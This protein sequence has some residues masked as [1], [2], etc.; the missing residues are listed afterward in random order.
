MKPAVAFRK[1]AQLIEDDQCVGC[2]VAL[3]KVTG[4]VSTGL[5]LV[6]DTMADLLGYAP[7]PAAVREPA[8]WWRPNMSE[9]ES[10]SP[11]IIALELAAIL[12]EENAALSKSRKC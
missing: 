2:C 6:Q 12:S 7:D 4:N 1:A 8:Y 10:V 9:H 5:S 11:R 3:I